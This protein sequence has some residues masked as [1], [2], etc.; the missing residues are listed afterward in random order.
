MKGEHIGGENEKKGGQ[1][2]VSEIEREG[3]VI[4]RER[5]REQTVNT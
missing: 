1:Q 2:G 3:T 4:R 5:A